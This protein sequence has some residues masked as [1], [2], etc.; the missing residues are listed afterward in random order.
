MAEGGFL[1]HIE[2]L[3]KAVLEILAIFVILLIPGWIFAP[4][5]LA[6]LQAAAARIAEQH[7]GK[8]FELRY[9]TLMEPFI[10]ELKAGMVLAFGAGLPLYFWRFWRFLAPALYRHEKKV[11]LGGAIAAWVLFAA[12]F[13][14]G[15]LGVMPMLVKFSLSFAREGLTPLIGLN[16]FVGL[17]MTVSLAFG[18]MFE[19]PLVLLALAMA[20][21]ISLD[22]LKKQ[23]PLVLVII[24]ILA[25]FLTPPDVISQLMLGVPTYLLFELTLIAGKFLVK[26]TPEDSLNNYETPSPAAETTAETVEEPADTGN[27]DGFS[28]YYRRPRK[29]RSSDVPP[30]RRALRR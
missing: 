10:V 5:L 2:A 20:G 13:A 6:M 30:R 14:L 3:R 15:V 26:K 1:S 16:N 7:G 8:G 12:G 29:R 21:V 24:L 28:Q 17:M 27:D 23:R 22:T 25:A 11:L 18:A 4:D 19:L 9:F